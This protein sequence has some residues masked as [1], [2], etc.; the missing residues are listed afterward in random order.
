MT[1]AQSNYPST[2]AELQCPPPISLGHRQPSFALTNLIFDGALQMPT[3]DQ[4][5][6]TA[7]LKRGTYSGDLD[8][9]TSDLL[10]RVRRAWQEHGYFTV[11][12]HGNAKMLTGSP[13][14]NLVA[15]DFRVV[16]G[17][18]YRLAGITLKNNR[19][20]ADPQLLRDLFPINDGDLFNIAQ[21]SKG[22]EKLANAYGQLGYINFTSIPNT[23]IN[24]ESQTISL[25][26]D[27]DEDK[28]FYVGSINI[29][30]LDEHASQEVLNDFPL[31][32][33][34]VFNQGLFELSMKRLSQPESRASASYKPDEPAGTVSIT[35][36]LRQCP[37]N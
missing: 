23:R 13:V 12:V 28:P 4:D 36:N 31:K 30:G 20:I 9:V 2:K 25:D 5:Q 29:K 3:A 18:Q 17:Q 10:E 34:D 1:Q 6:I 14:K 7:S 22:L 26:V 37:A 24:E 32:P 33:G 19:A 21:V 16:E 11:Q 15:A 8:A 35:I 27:V